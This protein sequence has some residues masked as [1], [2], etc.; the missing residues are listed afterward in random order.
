MARE[1]VDFGVRRRS[2]AVGGQVLDLRGLGGDYD[3]VFLPLYGAHQA[4][5]AACA[6]AAVEAFFGA[7]GPRRASTSTRCARRSPRSTSPGRLE[8]VRRSPTVVL[9][10]AHNPAGAAALA[11]ALEEAFTFE[12][13][14]GVVGGA[15]RQGRR[16]RARA[17]RAGARRGRRHDELLAAGDAGRASWPRSPRRSSATRGS[18]SPPRLDDAIDQAFSLAEADSGGRRRRA[19]DG[20][21]RDGRRGTHAARPA[22]VAC[23]AS[24]PP[25][26]PWA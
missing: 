17:A 3:D 11:A 5:N 6:L 21:D 15:R 2:V 16:G 25:R 4:H 24:R 22:E 18:R 19:R 20:L 12:R 26:R 23:D 14:I 13:L 7:R 1:G 10:G 9:D 8:I